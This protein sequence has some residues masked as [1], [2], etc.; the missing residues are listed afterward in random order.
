MATLRNKECGCCGQRGTCDPDCDVVTNANQKL[1]KARKKQHH[2]FASIMADAMADMDTFRD[3]VYRDLVDLVASKCSSISIINS[4]VNLYGFSFEVHV[5]YEEDATLG[6]V[7]RDV[8]MLCSQYGLLRNRIEENRKGTKWKFQM[9]LLD[10]APV[11][12]QIEK[13]RQS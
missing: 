3:M 13:E 8:E 4:Q 1:E 5:T 2:Q 6:C 9:P 11:W 12:D 7:D 10:S